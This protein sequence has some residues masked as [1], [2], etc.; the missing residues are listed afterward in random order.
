MRGWLSLPLGL[1]AAILAVTLVPRVELLPCL[2]LSIGLLLGSA[3]EIAS[4]VLRGL[5]RLDLDAAASTTIALVLLGASL[6]TLSLGQGA[7]GIALATIIANVAGLAAAACLLSRDTRPAA[8]GPPS[9][10]LRPPQ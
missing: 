9:E 2:L 10:M 1:G 7:P 4:Q 6:V 8:P 5:E 3:L